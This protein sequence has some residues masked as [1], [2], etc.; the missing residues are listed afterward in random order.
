MENK[1][2]FLTFYNDD[3]YTLSKNHLKKKGK[4]VLVPPYFKIKL[5]QKLREI[6][7]IS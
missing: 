6:N 3:I 7:R 4:I 2:I 1:K 5:A